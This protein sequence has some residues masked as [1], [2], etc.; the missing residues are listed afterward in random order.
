MFAEPLNNENSYN[1]ILTS[2]HSFLRDVGCCYP[3]GSI[4]RLG[5]QGHSYLFKLVGLFAISPNP[6]KNRDREDTAA[7]P[8]KPF[9]SCSYL[10]LQ[11]G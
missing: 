10:G 11:G 1:E 6:M 4:Y 8:F 9:V 5:K 2:D 7:I 3:T